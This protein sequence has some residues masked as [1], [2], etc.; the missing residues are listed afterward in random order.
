M[1]PPPHRG[2][3]LVWRITDDAPAGEYVDPAALTT[4]RHP[5]DQPEVVYGGWIESS[6]D[7]L[8]GADISDDPDT[9]T[10]ELFDELFRDGDDW[11]DT[12]AAE[13]P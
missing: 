5:K 10:P 13:G 7:L 8:H 6:F 12:Q 2:V 9:V 4:D 3:K 11:A 1:T